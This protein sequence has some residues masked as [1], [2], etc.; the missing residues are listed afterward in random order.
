LRLVLRL[1]LHQAAAWWREIPLKYCTDTPPDQKGHPFI[2]C[3]DNFRTG[4][5]YFAK[6][7]NFQFSALLSE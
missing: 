5:K 7:Q 2:L 4:G 6:H 3:K 1:V